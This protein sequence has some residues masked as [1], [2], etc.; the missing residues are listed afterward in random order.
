MKN[1]RHIKYYSNYI[2]EQDFGADGQPVAP[3]PV[4]PVYSFIFIEEGDKGDYSF[5]NGSSSKSYPSYELSQKDLDKWLN[6]AFNNSD[7][8]KSESDIK[9]NSLKE[10]IIGTKKSVTPEL[11]DIVEK[12]KNAV[13]SDIIG[14]KIQNTEVIFNEDDD[15]PTTDSIEVTFIITP[16]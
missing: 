1:L 14:Q 3:A 6:Q 8:S 5:P 4:D 7:Y 10:Y 12:F 2:A 9:K 11:K 16:K 13:V 15:I